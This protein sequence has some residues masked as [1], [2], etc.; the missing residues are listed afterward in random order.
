[1]CHFYYKLEKVNQCV[2][3][4]TVGTIDLT[5]RTAVVQ[6][7]LSLRSKYIRCGNDPSEMRP[8]RLSALSFLC[9]GKKKK[10]W[11]VRSEHCGTVETI[12]IT[13]QSNTETVPFL[14]KLQTVP[15]LV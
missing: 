5:K 13:L 3:A 10:E 4:R 6:V 15:F 12:Q 2:A 11:K 7:L 9:S 1:M 8:V 14:K